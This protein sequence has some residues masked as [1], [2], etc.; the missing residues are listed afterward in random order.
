[1]KSIVKSIVIGTLF[2]ALQGCAT[3]FQQQYPEP[4]KKYTQLKANKA[5][6]FVKGD[7]GAYVWGYCSNH[8]SIEDAKESAL[9]QCKGRHIPYKIE[10]KCRIYFVNDKKLIK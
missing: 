4:Y 3:T 6:A 7:D 9:F 1:M 2:V 8:E 5:F 10:K